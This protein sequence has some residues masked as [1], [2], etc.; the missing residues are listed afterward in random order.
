[1]LKARFTKQAPA[2]SIRT[3]IDNLNRGIDDKPFTFIVEPGIVAGSTQV[4]GADA[5]VMALI[6]MVSNMGYA[7]LSDVTTL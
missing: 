1:M 2:D 5:H 4:V 6:G 7:G 3:A